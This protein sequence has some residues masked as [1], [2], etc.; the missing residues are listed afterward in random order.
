M[1][2]YHRVKSTT[3]PVEHSR[4]FRG[5]HL[6]PLLIGL[7]VGRVC[8]ATFLWLIGASMHS[9]GIDT[10]YL[11]IF[12]REYDYTPKVASWALTGTLVCATIGFLWGYRAPRPKWRTAIVTPILVGLALLAC[13]MCAHISGGFEY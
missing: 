13:A 9:R 8:S 7:T 4:S 5:D 6:T 10:T 11:I 1:P 12:G 2:Y 3:P